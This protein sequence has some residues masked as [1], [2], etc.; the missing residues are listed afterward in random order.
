MYRIRLKE[1]KRYLGFQ[2]V[3]TEGNH[4]HCHGTQVIIQSTETVEFQSTTLFQM[5]SLL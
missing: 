3:L 1:I 2:L 4:P 5:H